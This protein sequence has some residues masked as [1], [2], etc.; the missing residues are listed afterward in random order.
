MNLYFNGTLLFLLLMVSAC[1]DVGTAKFDDPAIQVGGQNGNGNGTGESSSIVFSGISSHSNKTDSTVSLNW[2]PH[3]DA[4]AYDI[5]QVSSGS[6][7]WIQTV[8]G[9]ASS[10]VNLAGL[11]PN[12]A[13]QF[14]VRAKDA[15]GL[16][17][18]N[19]NTI[20]FTMNAAPDS[21]SG[22]SRVTPSAA[23]GLDTTPTIRV[24]GVKTGDTVRLYTDSS[25]TNAVA[26]LTATGATVDLTTSVLTSGT[27]QFYASAANSST[28]SPCSTSNVSYQLTA[29]PTGYIAVSSNSV[30]GTTS[31]F[32]VAKFEMK[33]VS[34]V[35]TSQAAST[36]WVAI[37]QLDAKTACTALGAG[38][39]LLS[40]PE[41]MTIAYNIE[42][43]PSNWTDG[44][45]G[46]GSLYRGHSD[47]NPAS[48]LAV[49][50]T[51][52]FYIGTG[53]S[54]ANAVGAGKEQRR[55]HT[56]SN[57]EVIWD[58]AGNAWESLDWSLGGPADLGPTSCTATLVE[59]S[60]VNCAALAAID[61]MPGNPASI[62]TASYRAS[63]GI[64][65]FYGG[66]GGTPRRGG[67]FNS[68]DY[69]GIF[70][71]GLDAG[72]GNPNSAVGFRCVYRP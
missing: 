3:A 32:C 21:P 65:K 18:S 16:N 24:S 17:D 51:A 26:S 62:P 58:F 59:I 47:N 10:F 61:Y 41:W 34:G 12:Q 14:R 4:V 49:T 23:S 56:L 36:P 29:C 39:D 25:C 42:A 30:L 20:S 54:A 2:T 28:S 53:N 6:A 64:G 45:V 1:H 57:G 38:Y 27:Y 9:Q 44:V 35:A 71:L 7:V 72:S 31:D 66:N 13:Y 5:Y 52:D 60:T 68:T 46:I 37:S 15:A 48:L 11:N 43:T 19:I 70:G 8:N 63:Y 55:T 69:A 67:G 22:L 33:N 40:N 50:N